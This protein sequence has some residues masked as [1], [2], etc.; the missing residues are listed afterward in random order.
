MW[1]LLT[2]ATSPAASGSPPCSSTSQ[3]PGALENN[4]RILV[5]SGGRYRGLAGGTR[6]DLSLFLTLGAFLNVRLVWKEVSKKLAGLLMDRVFSFCRVSN[7]MN[8]FFFSWHTHFTRVAVQL[9]LRAQ[10]SHLR[11]S[12]LMYQQHPFCALLCWPLTS[13]YGCCL[14]GDLFW[15]RLCYFLIALR[16][17]GSRVSSIS[18]VPPI[19]HPLSMKSEAPPQLS[20]RH[21]VCRPWRLHF[22]N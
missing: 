7:A 5:F 6:L 19:S 14:L 15:E 4:T 8:M 20:R 3:V 13:F 12:L 17:G 10:T 22:Q 21:W 2:P 11:P 1:N 18:H 16:V 9:L